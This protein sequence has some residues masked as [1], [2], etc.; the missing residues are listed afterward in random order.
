VVAA[1]TSNVMITKF[2]NMGFVTSVSARMA[3]EEDKKE[4]S[5]FGSVFLQHFFKI[6]RMKS[7]LIFLL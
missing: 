7:P 5:G 4:K 2:D 3:L 1:T 6:G